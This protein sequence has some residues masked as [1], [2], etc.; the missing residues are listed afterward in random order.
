ME[1]VMKLNIVISISAFSMT[2]LFAFS[3]NETDVN[4]EVPAID[5]QQTHIIGTNDIIS[6][7]VKELVGGKAAVFQGDIVLGSASNVQE[8]GVQ[9]MRFFDEGEMTGYAAWS[10]YAKWPNGVVPYT[11]SANIPAYD[12]ASIKEGM[13]W[14]ENVSNVRFVE[15]SNQAG[16][17]TIIRDRG[18]YSQVGYTGRAQNL[19]IG[20][21][22][23]TPGI[24]A[25]EFLH[26]LGFWHEQSRADRDQYVNIHWN[27]IEQGKE[28][29][30]EKKGEVTTSVGPYDV[31]SIMHYSYR[32]FSING[33]P[34]IT[35][36]DPSVP[37]DQ[38]GQRQRLSDYDIAALQET[39]G[40]GGTTP[41]PTPDPISATI[42]DVSVASGEWQY[43]VL[44]LPSG[45]RNLTITTYGGR[46]DVDLY[47]RKDARPTFDYYNCASWRDGNSEIC[48]IN[49]P[50][51][52]EWYIGVNGY[53]ASS[54][55]TITVEA[56]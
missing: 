49:S 30:F 12:V 34:T 14:I 38:L 9:P 6:Y 11:I 31:H 35:S 17:I 16:Y 1:V 8:Y 44:D 4:A 2:P 52:G 55:V 13:S 10:G 33:Q 56:D 51:A 18:C 39:Y 24:A 19:S 26:A 50:E 47:V 7:D 36:K 40:G 43:F 27:N 28:H 45:Y 23:G 41:P 37:N 42:T 22:C 32:A 21:G 29:N 48:D 15:R 5:T 3:A 54:G 46:G 20:Q 53:F 25:H